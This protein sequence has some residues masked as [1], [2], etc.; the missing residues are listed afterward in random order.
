MSQG[1]GELTQAV[2][3]KSLELFLNKYLLENS[4]NLPF[5]IK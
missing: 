2:K 5:K 1:R 3:D 4:N